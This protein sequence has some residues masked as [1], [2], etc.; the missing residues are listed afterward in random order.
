MVFRANM[1]LVS[2]DDS[3]ST[4][5]GRS[6]FILSIL[7]HS[8]RI[9]NTEFRGDISVVS[10]EFRGKGHTEYIPKKSR[11]VVERQTANYHRFRELIQKWVD[12]E[13]ELCKIKLRETDEG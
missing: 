4:T 6:P 13:I 10:P 2:T 1:P 8:N 7:L 5:I 12:A 9:R 11:A 3:T